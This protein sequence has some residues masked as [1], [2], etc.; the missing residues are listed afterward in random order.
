MLAVDYR[1]PPEHRFPAAPDDV[2][3]ALRLAGARTPTASASTRARV[4]TVGDS[5]GGN[6]ALVAALRNP[7]VLAGVRAGLPLRRRGD[8]RRVLRRAPTAG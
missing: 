3:T 2:D 6:L 4:A 5:A 7:G 8:E 1:R